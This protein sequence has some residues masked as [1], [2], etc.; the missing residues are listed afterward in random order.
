MTES[1]VEP[2]S[3]RPAA[4]A[5]WISYAVG[6]LGVFLAFSVT[7][8]A[9]QVEALCLWSFSGLGILS[10]VRPG[11]LHRSDAARMDWDQGRR[12]N[13]QIEVGLANASWGLV[14]LAAVEWDWGVAA[15]SAVVLIFGL[16]L[17]QA[18]G[19][20]AL[21]MVQ[22]DEDRGASGWASALATAAFAVVMCYFA[23]NGLN[24]AGLEPFA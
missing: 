9:E 7:E 13:F 23:V 4:I 10:F 22:G 11:L 18:F 1:E 8:A 24:E 12:N 16:Y 17:L 2:I 21:S 5:M 15:Q 19:L 14:A 6:G 20:H 3:T